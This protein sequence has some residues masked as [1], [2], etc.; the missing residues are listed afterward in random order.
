VIGACLGW[1]LDNN[2]TRHAS[3][4]DPIQIAAVKGLAAAPVTLTLAYLSGAPIPSWSTIAAAVVV[5]FF[6]YGVSLA[7]FVLALRHLGTGRT[8]AY[9]STAPFIGAAAAIPLLGEAVSLRLVAAGA[10]IAFGV[11]LHL[12]ERHRHSH[13]HAVLE[14]S[15]VHRHDETHHHH[16]HDGTEP[17]THVHVHEPVV[18][19]HAHTPDAHHPHT[20]DKG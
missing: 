11:W 5:G 2:F 8:G 6:G 10:L 7:L 17:H 4:A 14:H 15:H 13:A 20:H 12:T 18:H 16:G 9:F 19:T 1:G 3:L